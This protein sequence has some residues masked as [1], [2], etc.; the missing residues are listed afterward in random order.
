[1]SR[2]CLEKGGDKKGFQN[3]VDFNGYI[4]LVR[5]IQGHS[6]GNK[7]HPSLQDNAEITYK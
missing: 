7:V 4:L 2:D 3:C 5:A 1:M 6:G